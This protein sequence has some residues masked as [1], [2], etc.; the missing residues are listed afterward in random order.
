MRLLL[1]IKLHQTCRQR[2]FE[3]TFPGF[4]LLQQIW[5]CYLRNVVCPRFLIFLT[6]NLVNATQM[7]QIFFKV[8][9]IFVSVLVEPREP[10]SLVLLRWSRLDS[11][12]P[13]PVSTPRSRSGW[14]RWRLMW[15]L[16]EEAR[17]VRE[18]CLM[19]CADKLWALNTLPPSLSSMLTGVTSAPATPS[20]SPPSLNH[21]DLCRANSQHSETEPSHDQ[22]T[23]VK[24]PSSTTE[25]QPWASGP[26][27]SMTN[28]FIEYSLANIF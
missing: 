21:V 7:C 6:W 1:C 16:E 4:L 5:L 27:S 3:E 10:S 15:V 24:L 2:Y 23:L 25:S 8:K 19:W 17:C 13:T 14:A 22:F 9:R 20:S 11:S 26:A 18:R 28:N 12:H